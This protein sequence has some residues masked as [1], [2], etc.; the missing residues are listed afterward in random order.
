MRHGYAGQAGPQLARADGRR[1]ETAQRLREVVTGPRGL[2]PPQSD[3]GQSTI[4]LEQPHQREE[5]G[6]LG[7]LRI[8][9]A[10]GQRRPQ[11]LC[12]SRSRPGAGGDGGVAHHGDLQR[13]GERHHPLV[14]EPAVGPDA[15]CAA[16]SATA[17]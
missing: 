12:R 13:P 11:R 14:V 1:R 9:C 8:R 5:R 4:A 7:R 6:G 2:G 17:V 3:V 10:A 16:G 15:R